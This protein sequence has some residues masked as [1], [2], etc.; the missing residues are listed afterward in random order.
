MQIVP[1]FHIA[2]REGRNGKKL[3]GVIHSKKEGSK[4]GSGGKELYV[5]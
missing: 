4:G 2:E 1:A 5:F 3:E